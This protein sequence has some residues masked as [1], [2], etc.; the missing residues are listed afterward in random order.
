MLGNNLSMEDEEAVA[1]EL[2]EL[3]TSV[4]RWLPLFFFTN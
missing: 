4:V 1:A 2:L 3:Q